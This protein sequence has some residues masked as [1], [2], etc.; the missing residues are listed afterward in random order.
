[1]NCFPRNPD[2]PARARSSQQLK[3][4]F[5][6]QKMPAK[7]SNKSHN[8]GNIGALTSVAGQ[9]SGDHSAFQIVT[10]EDIEDLKKLL[11][12]QLVPTVKLILQEQKNSGKAAE[13]V[14]VTPFVTELSRKIDG[15]KEAIDTALSAAVKKIGDA[16]KEMSQENDDST[17]TPAQ[18]LATCVNTL[19]AKADS[20]Q[21]I[22]RL[23]LEQLTNVANI[24]SA[25]SPPCA[26]Q[27]GSVNRPRGRP[28]KMSRP[29][30]NVCTTVTATK[31]SNRGGRR[32][33]AGRPRKN[34]RPQDTLTS[35]GGGHRDGAAGPSNVTKKRGRRPGSVVLN[36]RVYMPED[37][38]Q[39]LRNVIQ[40]GQ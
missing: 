13:H 31:P 11:H 27:Q 24:M 9:C 16:V 6:A 2:K 14:D 32:V 18:I 4:F 25:R 17:P 38:P 23:M 37:V 21:Q 33:G 36:G 12:E 40:L 35:L 34:P 5:Q 19:N 10:S 1:M 28:P 3:S 26:V 15:I 22:Q 29:T 39:D 30:Q 8:G 20:E 7:A